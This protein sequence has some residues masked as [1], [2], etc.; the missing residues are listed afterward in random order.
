M[1]S[2]RDS[3]NRRSST[4]TKRTQIPLIQKVLWGFRAI[5]T[6]PAFPGTGGWRERER[7]TDRQTDRQTDAE[8]ET[9]R[10]VQR[11]R[12]RDRD[13]QR[14]RRTTAHVCLGSIGIYI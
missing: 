14:E 9:D 10:Q 2:K 8:T 5:I 13:R 4:H 6:L 1:F 11:D 12:S 7:E 3:K